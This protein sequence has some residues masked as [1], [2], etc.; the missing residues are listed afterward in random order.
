MS[1]AHTGAGED[2]TVQID[3]EDY[4]IREMLEWEPMGSG[5]S[6]VG[7]EEPQAIDVNVDTG[8]ASVWLDSNV[9]MPN[10]TAKVQIERRGVRILFDAGDPEATWAGGTVDFDPAAARSFGEDLVAAADAHE[11]WN[12]GQ[13]DE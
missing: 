8:Y 11:A 5:I 10:R 12:G 7:E 9:E 3:G 1:Q 13:A 6:T 4:D 2:R